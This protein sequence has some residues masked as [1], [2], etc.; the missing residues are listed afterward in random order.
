MRDILTHENYPNGAVH[1][2][3]CLF[4]AAVT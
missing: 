3:T 4:A 1:P 2:V